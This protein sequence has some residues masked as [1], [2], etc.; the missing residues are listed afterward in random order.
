MAWLLT[1][2][3]RTFQRSFEAGQYSSAIGSLRLIYEMTL[4][5]SGLKKTQDGMVTT[6][7]SRSQLSWT[8]VLK[9]LD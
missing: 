9:L 2:S 8:Q 4:K 7:I 3:E 5:E 6:S 1:Q